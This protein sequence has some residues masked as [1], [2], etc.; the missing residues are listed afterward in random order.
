MIR[1]A[2]AVVFCIALPVEAQWATATPRPPTRTPAPPPRTATPA[3]TRTPMRTST[4]LPQATSTPSPRRTPTPGCP[5][6]YAKDFVFVPGVPLSLPPVGQSLLLPN[7]DEF[8]AFV[9]F[10]GVGEVEF[11][12]VRVK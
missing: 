10:A 3:P 9:P 11:R 7:G 4:P 8:V 1:W 2:L 5:P 6:A 12:F